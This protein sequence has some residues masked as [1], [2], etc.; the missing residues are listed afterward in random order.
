MDALRCHQ[1]LLIREDRTGLLRQYVAK[2][3]AKFS[4]LASQDWLN[5]EADAV[6][7]AATVLSRYHPMEPEMVLQLFGAKLRQWHFTTVGGGK[8]DFIV[9]LPDAAD[10]PEHHPVRLYENAAGLGPRKD[11]PPGLPA[12]DQ[13][14]RADLRLA[15]KAPRRAG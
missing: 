1:D 9:P 13:R 4:D 2:Y 5:D 6:S 7:I 11:Q 8:R 10:L 14:Q 12:K 3:L 15:E